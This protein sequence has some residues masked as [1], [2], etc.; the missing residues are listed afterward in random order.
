M[1]RSRAVTVRDLRRSNRSRVLWEVFL[2]GPLTRQ[3]VGA[4]AGLSLATVSNLVATGGNKTVQGIGP[5]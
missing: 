2:H 4:L 1:V 5:Q 3:E